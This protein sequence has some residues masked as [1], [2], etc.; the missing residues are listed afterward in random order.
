[1]QDPGITF[2]V[3]A[4]TPAA[5][6]L[7][8]VTDLEDHFGTAEARWT[9]ARPLVNERGHNALVHAVHLAF[10]EHRRLCSRPTR[11]G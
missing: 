5:Q 11:C 7:E 3:D 8:L 9:P 6:P 1:M 2:A 10:S 4:V